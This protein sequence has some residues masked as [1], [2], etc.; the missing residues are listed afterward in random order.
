MDLFAWH[1]CYI[2]VWLSFQLYL[3][4]LAISAIVQFCEHVFCFLFNELSVF[5]RNKEWKR[6]IFSTHPDFDCLLSSPSNILRKILTNSSSLIFPWKNHCRSK[7]NIKEKKDYIPI[8]SSVDQT[9]QTHHS[10]K[11]G[12]AIV[13]SSLGWQSPVESVVRRSHSMIDLHS[14][15]WPQWTPWTTAGLSLL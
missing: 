13:V 2:D 7:F 14:D 1:W 6:E 10:H 12:T 15:E 8:Q 5:S 3:G 11:A 4:D 9:H